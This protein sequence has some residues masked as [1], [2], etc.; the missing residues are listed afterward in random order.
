MEYVATNEKHPFEYVSI[1]ECYK[2]YATVL[3]AMDWDWNGMDRWMAVNRTRWICM[4]RPM[5]RM[6]DNNLLYIEVFE[7]S[8]TLQLK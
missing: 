3:V 4:L 6:W 5:E 7:D 2:V 1:G 8:Q